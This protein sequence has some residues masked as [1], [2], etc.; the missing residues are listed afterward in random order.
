MSENEFLRMLFDFLRSG[1]L[2]SVLA[3]AILLKKYVI[4]GSFN[5]FCSLKEKE[6][7]ELSTLRENLL[8]VVEN[9]E[10]MNEMLS[11]RACLNDFRS[12]VISR[13]SA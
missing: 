6:V 3:A 13:S 11:E 5:R 8:K 2:V 10:L 1:G 9:Q 4:N 12:D 7:Q